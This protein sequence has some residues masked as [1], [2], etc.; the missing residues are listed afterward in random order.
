MRA[1]I[2]CAI[3]FAIVSV[4]VLVSAYGQPAAAQLPTAE[5]KCQ[6]TVA[7]Q[8][9][10]LFRKTF[11]AL[12]KCEDKI[13]KG[14]LPVTTDCTTETD[15]AAKIL[16]AESNYQQKLSDFC[17]NTTVGNLEFGGSCNGVTT[18]A[19]LTSCATAEHEASAQ[20]LVAL[21]YPHNV[22]ASGVNYGGAC[23]TNADCP[24]GSPL[25][26]G[27]CGPVNQGLDTDQRRC[28]KLLGKTVLKEA[29]KRMGTLQKCKK[30]VSKAKLPATTDCVTTSSVKLGDLLTLSRDKI[31]LACPTGVPA[32]L[33]VTGTCAGQ[34]AKE[35]VQSCSLCSGDHAA[36]DLIT[37]EYGSSP[38]G[39]TALAKQI[40]DTADCV[41]GPQSRCRADD[42]LLKNDKIRVVIQDLQRNLFGIGEFGGQIIDGDLVRTS[43]P[44]RDNFEEWSLS[45]NIE[46]TA[47]YTSLMVLND[48]SDG[49]PAVIRATGVDDLL[50]FVNPSAVIAGFG[51]VFPASANDKDLPV[52]ITTDYTLA[53]GKSYIQVDT[54]VENMGGS[55]INI[56]MGDYLNGSGQ[57][58]IFQPGSGFGEPLVTVE[59]SVPALPSPP[60]TPCLRAE[61]LR[62]F[63]AYGGIDQA[64]GVSYGYIHTTLRTTT[65]STAGVTV[66]QLATDI[67]LALIGLAAPPFNI[68]AGDSL[69]FT[70][71]FAVG[72][73]V[74]SVTDIRNE[75]QC[76][77]T[78]RLEGTVTAGGS[79]AV[80]ADVTILGALAA[81]S[82]GL[83]YNAVTHTRTDDTGNYALTLPPGSY[84]VV[85]NLDSYPFEGGGPSPVQ[86]PITITATQTT[87][88][89]VALPATGAMQVTVKDQDNVDSPAKV[90]VVGFD[91]SPDIVNPQT[92]A[93]I[94][95]R[96]GIFGDFEDERPFGVAKVIFV[97]PSG[98]SGVLPIEPGSYEVV[99]SRGIEYSTS[100]SSMTVA[101][102]P[103]PEMVTAKVEHVLDT[104]G[105]IGGDFH[106][107]SI[108]SPDSAV[109][110][111][112][113]VLA[114]LGEG[115]DFFTP[116][117][118]DIRVD[119]APTI[120]AM[121]ASGLL[122]TTTSGEIT[123]FDYGHFNA[124]PMTIDPTKV[125]GGSVDHGGAAPAG[126]D[127]PS[128]FNY[129]LTPGQIIAAAHA[130]PGVD[131]VQINHV[132]SHF[133]LDGGSG[134]AIDTGVAPPQSGV[135]AAAHRL[136]PGILNFFSNLPAAPA[137]EKFDALEIWIGDN[138]DQIYNNFLGSLNVAAKR[139]GNIGDWFNMINQGIISTGVADSDTH[140]T[141]LNVAG[142]PRTMV[143]SPSDDPQDLGGLA[144]TLSANVNAGHAIGT[145]GP[146]VRIEVS[147]AS[148]GQVGSL[149]YGAPTL[150]ATTDGEVAI[151]VDIQSPE[152][153]EFD[154][155]EYYVNT[156]TKK[157]T[158]N[159]LQSGA[160]LV[161]LKRY[162]VTADY[163]HSVTPTLQPAPGTTS[164]RW[165]VSDSLTLTGLTEDIWV[166]VLVKGQDNVSKPLFPV[167]ANDLKRS[168]NTTLANLTDGN[169]GEDGITALA[170]TNPLYVDVDGG[171]WTAPGLSVIP[172]P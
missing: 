90:S 139:G 125:N 152:W 3:A 159:N 99:T 168:T 104:D 117:E 9:R 23:V 36:D 24:S 12:A 44:D 84:N 74:S 140:N 92:V 13:S 166:V 65:F 35:S 2:R 88:Q 116:S 142:I 78:G 50:D 123:T 111:T 112:D 120:S 66:P 129:S 22:C 5:F 17:T 82:D 149:E 93:I 29:A 119:Y 102:S 124:W 170:F 86:H 16:D 126:A 100:T 62:N 7:K 87:T 115:V 147:A 109:K 130:D 18:V 138:R 71:Y 60:D 19:A 61:P 56:F 135:P 172:W 134:L 98:D 163:V 41:G 167:V 118:H 49:G 171:G 132:H 106:V 72:E 77:P 27:I 25:N 57:L 20:Q 39:A 96:T 45:L 165:E 94:N 103:V 108:F 79:P 34:T 47:H 64:D 10:K 169:L 81:T 67:F 144:E 91:P 156:T 11:K 63:V 150:I 37:V 28:Q 157:R 6:N 15:A 58:E 54:T 143:A 55:T 121:G 69:S 75:I 4:S 133:G 164:S 145:N 105:F 158:I 113:R 89:S 141:M 151:D 131:T 137:A 68:A 146:M 33:A 122:G 161:N 154:T 21:V 110:M 136:D 97:D 1:Q 46:A 40:T 42:Y 51:L 162:G 107:H 83:T 148:T 52:A 48:G 80:R 26:P 43:G 59:C 32:P 76:T 73:T 70:R 14:D 95:N 128:S 30:K 153:A 53:P 31:A 85:V 8:G 160:G 38:F 114:M 127:F 155:V 101:A